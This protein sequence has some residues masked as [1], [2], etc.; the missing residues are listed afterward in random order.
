MKDNHKCESML[1]AEAWIKNSVRGCILNI[2]RTAT[3][4]DLEDNHHLEEVGQTIY[5]VAVNIKFC[6]YCGCKLDTSEMMLFQT[7]LYTTFQ[8][9]SLMQLITN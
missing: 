5:Q 4:Q 1:L 8:S 3:E 7:S 9:G 6:P 2:N